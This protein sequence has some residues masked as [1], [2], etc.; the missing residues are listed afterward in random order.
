A[1]TL[2]KRTVELIEDDEVD[3]KKGIYEYLLTGNEKSLN[4]RTF[5]DKMKVKAFEIQ[6]G[7]CPV[8][9]K[10]YEFGEMEA[11]HIVPWR[12]GGKTVAENC[13]ML[14]RLDNRTKGGK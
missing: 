14:C 11:D 2:E 6:Q 4:L 10:H 9:N 12:M 8:C 7:I 13:R 3:N 5:D 1:A